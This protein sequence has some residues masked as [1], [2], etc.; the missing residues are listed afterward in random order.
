MKKN[1]FFFSMDAF[2][3]L[4]LFGTFLALIYSYYVGN[5]K[6]DQ[7]FYFSEDVLD[8][9]SNVKINELDLN[10][11]PEITKLINNNIITNQDKTIFEVLIELNNKDP[12]DVDNSR[13]MVEEIVSGII[14]AQYGFSLEFNKNPVYNNDPSKQVT[15]AI[16]RQRLI[17]G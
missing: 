17:I 2:L 16:A 8:V 9:F 12:P 6:L 5:P 13:V 3:A 10:Q 15:N 4:I 11:Y 1:G 7:P 14:P